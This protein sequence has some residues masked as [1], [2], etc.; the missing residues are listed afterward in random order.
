MDNFFDNDNQKN[1]LNQTEKSEEEDDDDASFCDLQIGDDMEEKL[2]KL[3]VNRRN[4]KT[5][6]REVYNNSNIQEILQSDQ[7][8]LDQVNVPVSRNLR[9]STRKSEQENPFFVKA[10]TFNEMTLCDSEDDEDYKP[11]FEDFLNISNLNTSATSSKLDQSSASSSSNETNDE[12]ESKICERTRSKHT[13]NQE[14][15]QKAHDLFADLTPDISQNYENSDNKD[16]TFVN[17]TKSEL[18]ETK[19]SGVSNLTES[20]AEDTVNDPD[21]NFLAQENDDDSRHST[22]REMKIS[23]LELKNLLKES[24]MPVSYSGVEQTKRS[25]QSSHQQKTN[26]VK[27]KLSKI[28]LMDFDEAESFDEPVKETPV[29]SEKPSL[30]PPPSQLISDTSLAALFGDI[31]CSNS[32]NDFNISSTAPSIQ[33]EASSRPSQTENMVTFANDRPLLAPQSRDS[34]VDDVIQQPV[35]QIDMTSQLKEAPTTSSDLSEESVSENKPLLKRSKNRKKTKKVNKNEIDD[36]KKM[37]SSGSSKEAK[38]KTKKSLSS[39][40]LHNLHPALRGKQF[41]ASRDGD[42]DSLASKL[43]QVADTIRPLEENT[44][45]Q[46]DVTKNIKDKL[47]AQGYIKR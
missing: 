24:K 17:W 36:E 14:E 37:S 30:L 2:M 43:M 19:A 23:K 29:T 44:M 42:S 1:D 6:I 21:F 5:L 3:G 15:L 18:W 27:E 28:R 46:N 25:S 11:N 26:T 7:D 8:G 35:D 34:Q 10:P 45:I 12:S 47:F 33:A 16:N 39:I 40:K 41:S 9:S 4:V 38:S 22:T 20:E 13:V 32:L 31:S